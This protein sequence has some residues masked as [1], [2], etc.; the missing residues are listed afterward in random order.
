MAAQVL[1]SWLFKEVRGIWVTHQYEGVTHFMRLPISC[2]SLRQMLELVCHRWKS[3]CSFWSA[4]PQLIKCCQERKFH[5]RENW[6]IWRRLFLFREIC[7]TTSFR[8]S[9]AGAAPWRI[10]DDGTLD[11]INKP[12]KRNTETESVLVCTCTCYFSLNFKV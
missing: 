7:W 10:C 9:L 4:V 12:C 5:K 1:R 6:S 8:L 2:V 11:G 3:L